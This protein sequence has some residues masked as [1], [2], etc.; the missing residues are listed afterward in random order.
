MLYII[1]ANNLA[2]K[3]GL[4]GRDDFDKMLIGRLR[5]YFSG[6]RPKVFLV[7]DSV[8]PMGDRFSD[9]PFE[10]IR[11]PRDD[12]YSSADDKVLEIVLKYLADDAFK[13]EIEVV[14]DDLDLT[15]KLKVAIAYHAK[16][17]RVK[18]ERST[19]LADKVM[20]REEF[21]TASTLTDK[22][23]AEHS[24]DSLNDEL[25]KIWGNQSQ[26]RVN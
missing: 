4:L 26:K 12:F 19:D 6:K 23:D 10:V 7:F 20:A 15:E 25:L 18:V 22:F 11:T 8:D 9:D 14:T 17:N 16:R 13:E 3:M 1:D 24:S 21:L 5:E 2:G